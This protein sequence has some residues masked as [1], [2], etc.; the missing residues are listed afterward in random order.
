[1]V[2][3]TAVSISQTLLWFLLISAM[4]PSTICIG[5]MVMTKQVIEAK[6]E[7]IRRLY[8]INNDFRNALRLK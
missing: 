3:L 1:M 5:V 2:I 8:E 7:E 6:D 4:L